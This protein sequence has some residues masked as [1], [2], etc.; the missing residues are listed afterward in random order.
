MG[1]G[2]TGKT[3][4]ALESGAQLINDFRDGVWLAELALFAEP[5]RVVEAVLQRR[6]IVPRL[7]SM[8]YDVTYREYEGRHGVTPAVVREGFEWFLT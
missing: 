6:V 5:E 3:R 1:T 4:L 7:Q 8:G 2:G